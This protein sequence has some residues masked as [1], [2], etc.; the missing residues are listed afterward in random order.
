MHGGY[1]HNDDEDDDTRNRIGGNVKM[2][3]HPIF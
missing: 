2:N 3:H 1:I